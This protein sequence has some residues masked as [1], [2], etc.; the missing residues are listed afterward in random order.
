MHRKRQPGEDGRRLDILP[1]LGIILWSGGCGGQAP[2]QSATGETAP[3][4][5]EVESSHFNDVAIYL[6]LDGAWMRLGEVRIGRRE[7]F[8][9]PRQ[10]AEA[11]RGFRLLLD[12]IASTAAFLTDAIYVMP[13]DR[14]ELDVASTLRMSSWSVRSPP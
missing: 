10:A 2:P 9:L 1:L 7:E 3:V 11:A 5:V 13:G 6:I 12:P 4:I 14:V 8:T